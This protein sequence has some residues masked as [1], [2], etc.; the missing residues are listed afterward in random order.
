VSR[1]DFHVPDISSPDNII[2]K[3][4][5]GSSPSKVIS[6]G[7]KQ[8]PSSLE[9]P[10]ALQ[11]SLGRGTAELIQLLQELNTFIHLNLPHNCVN[12][13]S[14]NA[15]AVS[16]LF[17]L[18]LN[19]GD[20]ILVEEFSYPGITNSLAA[21]SIKFVSIKMDH[22]GLIPDSLESILKEWDVK[23][24]GRRPHVLYLIP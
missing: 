10:T 23:V 12:L 19:D 2:D 7:H 1:V 21:R 17:R 16:K 15:D 9:I 5:A 22:F 6:I 13:H 18:L 24:K 3:W 4:R 14:G 11:Y 8:E 20:P